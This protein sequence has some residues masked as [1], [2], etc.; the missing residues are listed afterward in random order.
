VPIQTYYPIENIKFYLFVIAILEALAVYTWQF[1]QMPGAMVASIS[2][3]CKGIWLLALVLCSTS[4]NLEDKLFWISVQKIVGILLAYLWIIFTW[5]LSQQK[6]IIN[7]VTKYCLG[8]FLCLG[9]LQ[10]VNWQGLV[11]QR[12]WLDG[13]AVVI[14]WGPGAL[15]VL[16][17]TILLGVI[18]TILAMRWIFTS[19][20]LRR[21]Q[22][23]WYSLAVFISWISFFMWRT[24][25]QEYNEILPVGFLIN[26]IV[27]IWI[28][29]CLHMYNILPMAQAVAVENVVEGIFFV[30]NEDYIV[31]INAS[32]KIMLSGLPVT[33]G[34]KFDEMTAAW[35]AFAEVDSKAG[36]H[37]I[38]A[39]RQ[40]AEH[41]GFYQLTKIPLQTF[42]KYPL[43]RII[44]LKDLTEEK[45]TQA[46]VI[47]QQKFLAII[48]ERAS[49]ARELHDNLCQVLG[50]INIQAQS[51][52]KFEKNGQTD[53][54]MSNLSRLADVA[55][56]AYNDVREYIQD[57]QMA[58][59]MEKGLI[60]AIREYVYRVR[61]AGWDI[62]MDIYD[63][64]GWDILNN[65]KAL[66]VLR[67]VQEAITNIYKHAE[68]SHSSVVLVF[69]VAVLRI[70]VT[71]NGRGFDPAEHFHSKSFGLTSM[72]ERAAKIGGKLEIK[73]IIGQGTKVVVEIPKFETWSG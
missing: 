52:L 5:Q 63:D 51:I 13:Q 40:Q 38:E 58:K 67:I 31:D 7:F 42:G 46:K 4:T 16:G 57:V 62:E 18:A 53:A 6:K 34:G 26:G 68:A 56:Q 32:A 28:C 30:D 54:V 48:E 71:D 70:I 8:S 73:S 41:H 11:W 36:V 37:R 43:G 59:M 60:E 19:V 3:I 33:I 2:Q 27:V 15:I 44:L 12:A 17:Y 49:F 65:S 64:C 45:R 25:G 1:R 21:Q 39:E 23:W 72:R 69:D 20:G 66:E 24:W 61:Q 22:A 55:K 35:P 29:Y 14:A 9:L 10:I 47:E 50:Y